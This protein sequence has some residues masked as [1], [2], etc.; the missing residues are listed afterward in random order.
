MTDLAIQSHRDRVID[1]RLV[2]RLYEHAGW[3][4]ERQVEDIAA[5]LDAGPAAG[6]WDGDKLVGF[7][8]AVTDGRFRAY[9]EDIVVQAAYRRQGVGSRLV[10]RLLE[11]LAPIETVSLFCAPA[12]APFYGGCGFRQAKQTVM[13]R[14]RAEGGAA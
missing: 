2:R 11:E 14:E 8:R 5:I 4:P 1:A 3:W 12:L 10:A 6:A 13:H 7:G 9:L